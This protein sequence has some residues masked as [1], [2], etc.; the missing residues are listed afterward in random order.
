MKHIFTKINNKLK[1]LGLFSKKKK[2]SE[3]TH[4]DLP[5]LPDHLDDGEQ[6]VTR[7]KSKK[8]SL[9]NLSTLNI[10]NKLSSLRSSNNNKSQKPKSAS[11]LFKAAMKKSEKI[12]SRLKKT[13][14]GKKFFNWFSAVKWRN[15]TT[16]L[17]YTSPSP[18]DQR[19]SRM[20]SSA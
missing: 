13:K 8:F 17:L 12:R 5:D 18:R 11:K 4:S 1:S 16:C 14:S 15:L 10:K 3:K 9:K 19:G 7:R 2:S 20:P 6:K